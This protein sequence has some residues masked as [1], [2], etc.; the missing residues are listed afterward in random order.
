MLT[1]GHPATSSVAGRGNS[2]SVA[3]ESTEAAATAAAARAVAEAEP[4][5]ETEAEATA[6][7]E[8]AATLPEFCGHSSTG[9]VVQA[10]S[11]AWQ[12]WSRGSTQQSGDSS[13][14]SQEGSSWGGDAYRWSGHATNHYWQTRSGNGGLGGKIR[15]SKQPQP[16]CSSRGTVMDN[17]ISGGG[18]NGEGSIKMIRSSL[19]PQPRSLP[20]R[21]GKIRSSVEPTETAAVAHGKHIRS[22]R[23]DGF[24]VESL[25][26]SS[27]D[28]GG[29][30]IRSS[31]LQ[32]PPS[33]GVWQ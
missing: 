4:E 15:S 3:H 14:C 25:S 7:P 33:A 2:D 31:A 18:E 5:A 23:S 1:E 19:G 32:L 27:G 8:T 10:A 12:Y 29:N 16:V 13:W 30:K 21:G 9:P 24:P 11:V 28:Q 6:A 20:G 17:N 26:S 22:C